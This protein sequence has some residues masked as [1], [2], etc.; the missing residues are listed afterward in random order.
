MKSERGEETTKEKFKGSKGWIMKFEKR[1]H[2][3][4]LK[5]QDE[6]A[7]A[8]IE[9]AAGYPQDLAKITDEVVYIKYQIFNVDKTAL[10]RFGSNCPPKAHVFGSMIPH[11]ERLRWDIVGGNRSLEVGPRRV[12]LFSSPFHSPCL[13]G[14]L[15]TSAEQSSSTIPFHHDAMSHLK[16]RAIKLGNHGLNPLKT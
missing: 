9:A 5:V 16:P 10:L 8:D 6:T 4:N 13:R 1:S 7:R 15:L 14:S 12:Y 3:H 2:L 11:A